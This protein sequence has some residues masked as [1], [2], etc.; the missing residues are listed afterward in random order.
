MEPELEDG[1][2]QERLNKY[3]PYLW[4]APVALIVLLLAFAYFGR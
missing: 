3:L 2:K 1:E 4:I